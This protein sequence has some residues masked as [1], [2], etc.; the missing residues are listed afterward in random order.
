M[1]PRRFGSP[2]YSAIKNGID[3]ARCDLLNGVAA[4][5]NDQEEDR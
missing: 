2:E 4:I 5:L 1:K 3:V